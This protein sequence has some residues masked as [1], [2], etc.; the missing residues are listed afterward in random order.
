MTRLNFLSAGSA[1]LIK[2]K[3]LSL[4]SKRGNWDKTCVQEAL[5]SAFLN[6]ARIESVSLITKMEI[7]ETNQARLWEEKR[8]IPRGNHV[9]V[10][11]V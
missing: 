8:R 10:G 3:T 5:T 4:S 2:P 1:E 7:E 11:S 6:G 9:A